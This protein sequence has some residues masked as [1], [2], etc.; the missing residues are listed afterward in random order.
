MQQTGKEVPRV[1]T[2]AQGLWESQQ[3]GQAWAPRLLTLV[4]APLCAS[5]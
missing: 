1:M 3:Q 4:W 5:D 2:F